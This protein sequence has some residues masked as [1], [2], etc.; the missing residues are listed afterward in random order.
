MQGEFIQA[1]VEIFAEFS[2]GDGLLQVLV[3]GTDEPDIHFYFLVGTHR[4]YFPFLDGPQELHL[5]VITQ[6]SHF[7]E[8]QRAAVGFYESSR[9]VGHGACKRTF[10]V[11][12]KFRSRQFF[13]HGSA[14]D[15]Y[16]RFVRS[17][18]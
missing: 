1:V 10:H 12:E 11:A 13:E 15:G 8:K 18:A 17:L 14:V 9:F 3:G 6:V 2:T 16:K 4:T 7:V 5:H